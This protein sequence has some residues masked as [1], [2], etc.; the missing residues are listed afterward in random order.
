[1]KVLRAE[2]DVGL[3]ARIFCKLKDLIP[4]L[5]EVLIGDVPE[6]DGAYEEPRLS[7]SRQNDADS[8]DASSKLASVPC[9]EILQ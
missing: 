5:N 3:S 8:N 4:W 7:I 1:M 6:V 2:Y 9:P